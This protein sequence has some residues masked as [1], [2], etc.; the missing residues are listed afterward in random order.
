LERLEFDSEGSLFAAYGESRK[1]ALALRKHIDRLIAN[2]KSGV[3]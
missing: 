2:A 1:D 3:K